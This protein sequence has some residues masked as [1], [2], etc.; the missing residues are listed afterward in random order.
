MTLGLHRLHVLLPFHG[1]CLAPLRGKTLAYVAM[2][3]LG[4]RQQIPEALQ[5][6]Q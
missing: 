3:P 2:L 4:R 6:Y 5:G 1:W